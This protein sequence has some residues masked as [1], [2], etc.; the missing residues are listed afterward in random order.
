M[1]LQ[2]TAEPNDLLLI[3]S[4]RTG[5]G[6]RKKVDFFCLRVT[7]TDTSSFVMHT[8]RSFIYTLFLLFQLRTNDQCPDPTLSEDF[9][10][11]KSQIISQTPHR[12]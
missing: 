4:T 6:N 1:I 10:A 2:K 12:T 5:T 11:L 7:G 8:N 3:G 9:C